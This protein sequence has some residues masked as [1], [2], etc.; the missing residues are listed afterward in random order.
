MTAITE[1]A[2]RD[3]DALN[4]WKTFRYTGGSITR[5][6]VLLA[7]FSSSDEGSAMGIIGQEGNLAQIVT[8]NSSYDLVLLHFAVPVCSYF[9]VICHVYARIWRRAEE[10]ES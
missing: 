6:S 1:E 10:A 4:N 2:R 8:I 7:W 3:N 9:W 5:E